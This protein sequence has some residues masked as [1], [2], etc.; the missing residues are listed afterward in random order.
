VPHTVHID[1]NADL[2]GWSISNGRVHAARLELS[3]PMFLPS[4]G[5]EAQDC[6]WDRGWANQYHMSACTAVYRLTVKQIRSSFG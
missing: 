4:F 2:V 3:R 5:P 6:R 1:S